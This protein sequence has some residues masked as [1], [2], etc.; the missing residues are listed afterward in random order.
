M[1]RAYERFIAL[2]EGYSGIL[3]LA[4][5]GVVLLGVFFRYL[6]GSSL[7]WYDEFAGYILVWLTM[8]GSVV[9][10]A[11]RKHIGFETLQEKL[12]PGGRRA[13]EIFATLCVLGFSVVLSVS[14][15]ILMKAMA[16][17]TAVSLPGVEMAW[18]YSVMPASGALMVLVGAIQLIALL[19][20]GD[21]PGA[22]RRKALE[23]GQ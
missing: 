20:G 17:E 16:A 14:G 7:S 12:P 19:R 8:Y 2:L 21:V 1:R 4:M 5:L 15:W 18:V 10:L 3:M 22:S 6:L 23:E 9:G 13:V 11:R